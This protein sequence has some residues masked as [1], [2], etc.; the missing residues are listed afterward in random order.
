MGF[1]HIFI[2]DNDDEGSPFIGDYIDESLL[3]KI[4]IINVRG[5]SANLVQNA[6]YQDFYAKYGND[7]D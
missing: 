5:K 1:S 6:W 2:Y 3:D 4:T 7:F